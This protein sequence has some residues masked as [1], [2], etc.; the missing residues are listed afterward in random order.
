MKALRPQTM[1]GV[2][3]FVAIF[4]L[5]TFAANAPTQRVTLYPPHNATTAEYDDSKAGFSFKY[6]L[7]KQFTRNDWD[8]GYGFLQIG[9]ED[10]FR[11]NSSHQ[12]RSV[13]KDLG[14]F[15][16]NDSID[17]PILEP[18][19]E[20]AKGEQRK[21]GVD[22]S[23]DTHEQWAKTTQIFAKVILGHMYLVRIK[24]VSAD[25]Y[26]LFRVED[27]EQNNHCMISWRLIPSPGPAKSTN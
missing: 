8:L 23:A 1:L 7:L 11:V 2:V 20:L 19:P 4:A 15:G 18:L 6:G 5:R 21:I 9:G 3:A 17:L 10:W 22:A 25:F 16:W 27:F 26:V 12:S 13:M 24:D 14:E